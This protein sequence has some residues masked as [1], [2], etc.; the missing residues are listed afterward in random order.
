LEISPKT[1]NQFMVRGRIWVDAEDFAITRLEGSPAKNPSFWIHSIHVVHRYE[2]IGKFWLPV[3]NQSRAE[4]R[5]FG[6]TEV[7]IEYFDYL[8]TNVH[9]SAGPVSGRAAGIATAH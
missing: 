8:I 5:I 7:G 1:K 2:R 3:M 9:A 6:P 4:A